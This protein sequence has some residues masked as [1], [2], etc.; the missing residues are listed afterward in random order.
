MSD[1]EEQR[2]TKIIE[3]SKLAI[4]DASSKLDR[5]AKEKG[6]AEI[7]ELRQKV[8]DLV[9][10]ELEQSNEELEAGNMKQEEIYA[11]IVKNLE[12]ISKIEWKIR[13]RIPDYK[14]EHEDFKREKKE[15]LEKM[16][17]NG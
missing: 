1:S 4:K 7:K 15:A 16:Y 5:I 13:Q 9:G 8:E 11:K 10:F 6:E 12:E 14:S 3:E 2:L 17:K